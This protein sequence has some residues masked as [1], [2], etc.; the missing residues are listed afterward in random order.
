[1]AA[2]TTAPARAAT[3]WRRGPLGY[4]FKS[5]QG[6]QFAL[7]HGMTSAQSRNLA[8]TDNVLGSADWLCGIVTSFSDH[9]IAGALVSPP[10]YDVFGDPAIGTRL[11]SAPLIFS[12]IGSL[13]GFIGPISFFFNAKDLAGWAQAVRHAL[14]MV[15]LRAT[16]AIE[17]RTRPQRFR[18]S[19]VWSRTVLS[20]VAHCSVG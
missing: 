19:A 11:T 17:A 18:D 4:A 6:K 10:L 7:N 14:A 2:G 3:N 15:P 8:F 16:L 1:M 12:A 9:A 20:T 5:R 13:P